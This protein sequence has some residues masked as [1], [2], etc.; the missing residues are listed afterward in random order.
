M[1]SDFGC[2]IRI[3]SMAY[4]FADTIQLVEAV[5]GIVD[6]RIDVCPLPRLTDSLLVRLISVPRGFV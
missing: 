5:A 2:V 3:I 6:S 4:Y 1:P